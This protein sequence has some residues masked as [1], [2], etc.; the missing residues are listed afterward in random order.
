LLYDD[1]EEFERDYS[2]SE[3][4]TVKMKMAVVERIVSLIRAGDFEEIKNLL[5]DQETFRYDK[6]ELV[7]SMKRVDPEFGEVSSYRWVGFNFSHA[8][9]DEIL[10]IAGL[11]IREKNNHGLNIY[12]NP[13]STSDEVL[14]IDYKL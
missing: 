13:K 4:E 11:L 1:G 5:H 6:H 10:K 8:G 14:K 7:E 9:N 2:I 3:L 12:L